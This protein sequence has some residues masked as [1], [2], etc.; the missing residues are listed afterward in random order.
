[1][2]G[3]LGRKLGMSQMFDDK[4]EA[5]PVT[6]IEAGP[7]YVTQKKTRERDG[8]SA[9]QLGFEVV[10]PNRLNKPQTAR[11]AKHNLPPLRRLQEFRVTDHQELTEGQ[12]L[13]VSIFEVGNRVDVIGISKGRGFAGV[14]K[15]HHFKGGP[16]T[17]GQSDRLRAP[18]A[19]SAGTT[20]GRVIKGMRMAGRMGNERV[21]VQNLEVV[22]V[23]PERNLLA[24]RGAVPGAAQ[25]L[26]IVREARKSRVSGKR[27]R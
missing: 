12:Q 2:K 21:T 22:L 27:R 24:I 13:D 26:L 6:V 15:R 23:D 16:R 20:P 19:I 18:G 3:I 10:K 5:I 8:Y 25:G 7:C 1:M 17:H 9:V 4:G 14:V 11:L